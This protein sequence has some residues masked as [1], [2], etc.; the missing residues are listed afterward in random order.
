VGQRRVPL[1]K[2]QPGR[3]RR[4]G[5]KQDDERILEL[6]EE[7]TPAGDPTRGGELVAAVLCEAPARLVFPE[8]PLAVGPERAEDLVRRLTIRLAHARTTGSMALR[9]D[10]K[11]AGLEG[12]RGRQPGHF[13]DLVLAE[14]LALEE[15]RDERVERPPVLCDP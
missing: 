15:R 11:R 10:G 9:G 6:R 3:D 2:P 14:R 7:L 8:A 1:G 13:E 5:E 4:R 12:R